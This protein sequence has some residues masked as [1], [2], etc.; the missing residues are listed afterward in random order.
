MAFSYPLGYQEFGRYCYWTVIRIRVDIAG[1]F[2]VFA[3]FSTTT[4]EV[5]PLGAFSFVPTM[6]HGPDSPH[7]FAP[8]EIDE[9]SH[10]SGV[11]EFFLTTD[12]F[13]VKPGRTAD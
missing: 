1:Y 8:V 3:T 9:T 2:F 13:T 4:H 12:F 6:E 10:D 11:I 5:D 7:F